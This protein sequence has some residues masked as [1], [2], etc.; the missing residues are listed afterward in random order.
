MG[1]FV[2]VTLGAQTSRHGIQ[3]LWVVRAVRSVALLAPITSKARDRIV[4]VDER[5]G[6]FGMAGNA[7]AFD[8]IL[9]DL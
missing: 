8:R 7:L 2:G 4:L 9:L 5:T 3:H 6:L 1:K